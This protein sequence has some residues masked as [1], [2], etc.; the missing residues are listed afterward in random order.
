MSGWGLVTTLTCLVTSYSGFVIIR[1]FLGITEAGLYPGSYFILSMWYTPKE[2]ATRMAIFYGANT[3][4]GAFGG[5]IAYGVGNLDGAHGWR[6]W[7]WLF[8]IEGLITIVAG[9]C[10]FWFLP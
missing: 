2:L 8:L 10:C 1:L 3:A 7:K 5:V 6:A 9:L 4:A